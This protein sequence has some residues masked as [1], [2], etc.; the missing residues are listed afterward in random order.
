MFKKNRTHGSAAAGW[1]RRKFGLDNC[2]THRGDP[3]YIAAQDFCL[4]R[5]KI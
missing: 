3:E 5:I 4:I 1:Y 2:A